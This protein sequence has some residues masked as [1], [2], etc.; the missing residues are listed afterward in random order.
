[1]KMIKKGPMRL[2]AEER[3]RER[4][5]WLTRKLKSGGWGKPRAYD[6]FGHEKNANDVIARME[7]NNPGDTYREALSKAV[8]I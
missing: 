2:R 3:A 4:Q 8:A 5:V 7:R 6:L 1:M